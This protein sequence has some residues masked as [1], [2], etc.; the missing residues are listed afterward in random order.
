M[1]LLSISLS[2]A[3]AAGQAEA[4]KLAGF[5]GRDEAEVNWL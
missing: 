1:A 2:Q 5:Y 3:R 4:D